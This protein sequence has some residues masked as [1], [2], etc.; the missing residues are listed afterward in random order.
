[1]CNIRGSLRRLVVVWEQFQD[2]FLLK[3]PAKYLSW[4]SFWEETIGWIHLD[5]SLLRNSLYLYGMF[6]RSFLRRK[7]ILDIVSQKLISCDLSTSFAGAKWR[8]PLVSSGWKLL[9]LTSVSRF[10]ACV[11]CPHKWRI[12]VLAKKKLC[13]VK[14]YP[15]Y[16]QVS[17]WLIM[18]LVKRKCVCRWE[19]A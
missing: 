13:E 2:C 17:W 12:S 8:R 14:N 16:T 1:M 10:L 7:H 15:L 18:N 6:L 19:I 4:E 5:I 3:L 9:E 11:T